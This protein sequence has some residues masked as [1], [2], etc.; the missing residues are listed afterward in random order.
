MVYFFH[1]PSLY[2]ATYIVRVTTK[3]SW[4]NLVYENLVVTL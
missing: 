4:H 3:F 1:F 2:P